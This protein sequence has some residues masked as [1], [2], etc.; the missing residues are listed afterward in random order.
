MALSCC[1][2]A[3]KAGSLGMN[4]MTKSGDSNNRW[5]SLR[6]SSFTCCRTDATCAAK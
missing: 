3:R 6:L 2:A 4:M 5:Y 1:M